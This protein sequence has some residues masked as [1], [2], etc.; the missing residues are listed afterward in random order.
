MTQKELGLEMPPNGRFRFAVWAVT[1]IEHSQWYGLTDEEKA[2]HRGYLET[3]PGGGY[4]RKDK[5]GW[6][7]RLQVEGDDGSRFERCGI[8]GDSVFGGFGGLWWEACQCQDRLV[9]RWDTMRPILYL[10]AESAGRV[11]DQTS[12]LVKND[13]YIASPNGR[14]LFNPGEPPAGAWSEWL[15]TYPPERRPA[16][17]A[18]TAGAR[19]AAVPVEGQMGLF[20][21]ER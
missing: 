10:V 14:T 1:G 13:D 21:G 16:K 12:W 2:K 11:A 7:Y 20:G 4:E 18:Q 8:D 19:S 5:R 3:H 6:A 17:A 15:P 9:V